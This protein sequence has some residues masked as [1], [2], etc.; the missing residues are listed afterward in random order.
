MHDEFD[1]LIGVTAFVVKNWSKWHYLLS[2]APHD[3]YS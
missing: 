3:I 2:H 1:L